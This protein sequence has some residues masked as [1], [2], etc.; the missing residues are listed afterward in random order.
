M[1]QWHFLGVFILSFFSSIAVASEGDVSEHYFRGMHFLASYSG[2]DTE[3]LGNVEQLKQEMLEAV[4][5]CGATILDQ[6]S[7]LFPPNGLTMVFLL[8]ESHAS[9][10]TY[11]EHGACFV[12][13]FTCGEKCSSIQFD[14]ALRKY[15]RPQKVDSKRILRDEGISEAVDLLFLAN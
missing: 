7:Y 15:L 11:P 14:Q 5:T 4:Q 9:I 1:K 6:T 3:A 2:C 13:L 12:D 10:H 8:S